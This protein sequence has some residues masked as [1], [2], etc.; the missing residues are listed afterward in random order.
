MEVDSKDIKS[1]K[2]KKLLRIRIDKL[3]FN[4]HVEDVH[5]G[6]LGKCMY[7]WRDV[8]ERSERC[9]QWSLIANMVF[10][11]FFVIS[12]NFQILFIFDCE[13]SYLE[14]HV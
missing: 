12:N 14:L 4:K 8:S 11:K 2:H 1:K 7:Q 10:H 6:L 13:K 3:I 5:K 9:K